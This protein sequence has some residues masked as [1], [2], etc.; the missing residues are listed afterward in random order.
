MAKGTA[1]MEGDHNT[2]GAPLPSGEINAT[3]KKLGLPINSSICLRRSLKFSQRFPDLMYLSSS[4]KDHWS[5]KER[6][7]TFVP[8]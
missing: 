7:R 5:R 8:F 6:I 4:W 2:H 1:S 3:K